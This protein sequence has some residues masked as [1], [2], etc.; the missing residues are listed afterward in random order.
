MLPALLLAYHLSITTS[1]STV[2][3]DFN[4][5]GKL[6]LLGFVAAVG[7]ALAFTFVRFRLRDK[8]AESSSFVSISTPREDD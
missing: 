6:L 4:D 1:E 5:L 2:G 7:V 8:R 3:E